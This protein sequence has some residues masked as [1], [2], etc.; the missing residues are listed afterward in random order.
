MQKR[1]L[2]LGAVVLAAG[3]GSRFGQEVGGKL[4]VESNGRPVLGH[5]LAALRAAEVTETVVVLGTAAERIEEAIDWAAERRVTNPHPERGLASS[6]AVGLEALAQGD[7]LDGAF[8]V[9]GDQPSLR[10]AVVRAL[11][12]AAASAR[13]G[14]RAYVVPRYADQPGPRNPVLL[15]RPA[16]PAAAAIEGD[17]GLAELIEANP[18]QVIEVSVEGT[19]PDID[20][21]ADLERL[22]R[23]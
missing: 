20:T 1:R 6:L 7:P 13:P 8:I 2:E 16:W 5:V 17:R 14:D 12:D 4:L 22:E 3:A 10:P 19:M 23:T 21:Q 11:A 15:L 9:L 18:D